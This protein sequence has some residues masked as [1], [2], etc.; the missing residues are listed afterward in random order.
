MKSKLKNNSKS[1]ENQNN[2]ISE[3]WDIL[4]TV[5]YAV[6]IASIF[7]SFLF[8]PFH[9]PSGSMKSNLLAGDY[10]FVSKY[11]YGYSKYSFPFS[12]PLFEGR[13]GSEKR[14]ERG[15]IAVFRLPSNPSISYIKRII[16]VAGDKIQIK[17]GVTY[18]NG[19]PLPLKFVDYYIDDETGDKIARYTE[20]LPSGKEY[21]VLDQIKSDAG[22]N[23]GFDA[24]NTEVYTVPEGHYFAMGDN[25]DNSTDSRYIDMSGSLPVGMVPEENLVGEAKIIGF[26]IYGSVRFWQF[27]KLPF[28]FRE[29]RFFKEINS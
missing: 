27:W 8:E 1:T 14:P 20:I 25:R 7:R 17:N 13:I 5:V 19:N 29:G 28:S 21:V 16:G 18:L 9:I 24:D 22:I 10:I 11:S 2:A 4:K 6:I 23:R 15:D 3:S 26:S 12:L